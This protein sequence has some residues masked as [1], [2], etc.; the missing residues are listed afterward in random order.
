MD[1]I[2]HLRSKKNNITR[3]PSNIRLQLKINNLDKSCTLFYTPNKSLK[4]N[5]PFK[6]RIGKNYLS[7]LSKT[8]HLRNRQTKILINNSRTK[9]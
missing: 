5:D 4:L 1:L 2:D 3:L 8:S 9:N 6:Q 7:K